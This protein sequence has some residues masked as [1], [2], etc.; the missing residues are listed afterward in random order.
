MMNLRQL[1]ILGTLPLV[2]VGWCSP[3][4]PP[5]LLFNG[6][7]RADSATDLP[8]GLLDSRITETVLSPPPYGMEGTDVFYPSW[9]ADTW[10]N[11]QSTNTDVQAPCGA[12]LFGG[13]QVGGGASQWKWAAS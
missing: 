6:N 4:D 10:K 9:F 11:G 13:E 1:R 7:N 3:G 2:N 8:A 12:A 5:S